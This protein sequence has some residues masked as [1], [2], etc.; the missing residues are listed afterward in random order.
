MQVKWAMRVIYI[1]N[2]YIRKEKRSKTDVG[3]CFL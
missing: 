1:F 2:A 3:E